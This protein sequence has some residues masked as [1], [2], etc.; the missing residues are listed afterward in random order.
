MSKEAREKMIE[1][2]LEA[3]SYE[4][5]VKNAYGDIHDERTD[6]AQVFATLAV[7]ERLDALSKTLDA[8]Y[9]DMPADPGVL[10]Q[11]QL[12]G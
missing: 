11:A 7:A 5:L 1:W 6:R 2:S 12:E 8:M 3:M 9:G 4:M 10:T